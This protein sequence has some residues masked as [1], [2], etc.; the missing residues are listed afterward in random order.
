MLFISQ[1]MNINVWKIPIAIL[2]EKRKKN[3]QK[4]FKSSSNRLLCPSTVQ[5]L[6]WN[7]PMFQISAGKITKTMNQL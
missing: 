6:N 4:N 5:N 7:Q 2:W 3:K 1:V